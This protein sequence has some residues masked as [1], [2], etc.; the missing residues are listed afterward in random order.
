MSPD[1]KRKFN[2][3]I[4]DAINAIGKNKPENFSGCIEIS[5]FNKNDWKALKECNK[6]V[7]ERVRYGMRRE[8]T[9]RGTKLSWSNGAKRW[10]PQTP[11][12]DGETVKLDANMIVCP[13]SIERTKR[14]SCWLKDLPLYAAS[15]EAQLRGEVSRR[16]ALDMFAEGHGISD[17]LDELP[18]DIRDKMRKDIQKKG[19]EWFFGD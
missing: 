6:R 8:K 14:I 12:E 4:Q 5:E 17:L 3:E 9:S 7:E 10:F 2:P 19:W 15:T 11:V 13:L 1:K 16:E 18:K